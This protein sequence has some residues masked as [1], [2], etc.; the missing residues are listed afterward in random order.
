MALNDTAGTTSN[1]DTQPIT[2]DHGQSRPQS[3]GA[4]QARQGVISGR[5]VKVL[6]ISISLALVA[7]FLSYV[8]AV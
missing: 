3:L 7:M 6:G 1:S 2:D 5:V 8:L 4:V